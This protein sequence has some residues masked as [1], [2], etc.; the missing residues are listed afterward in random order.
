M[1]LCAF[2]TASS[3]AQQVVRSS[4]DTVAEKDGIRSI[5]FMNEPRVAGL[6]VMRFRT[7]PVV[8]LALLGLLVLIVLS[9]LAARNKADT[10]Y[11]ELNNLNTRYLDVESRLRRVRSDL[12]LSGILVRDYLLDSTADNTE[13]QS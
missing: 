8:A 3:I 9:L 11:T 7:W 5:T 13:Y 1:A 12:H 6:G 4:P 10:A 2:H